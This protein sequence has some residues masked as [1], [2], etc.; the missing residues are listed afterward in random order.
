MKNEDE[1]ILSGGSATK[2]TRAG[3]VV[4]RSTKPQSR[5]VISF[6]S[7]LHGAGFRAAP[8]PVGSGFS[9]DGRVMLEYI[10]AKP[11]CSLMVMV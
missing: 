5:M 9:P 3:D 1:E 4:Y 6:L 7:F 8:R 11:D 2:V 10:D